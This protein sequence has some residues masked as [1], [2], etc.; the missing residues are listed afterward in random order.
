MGG[1]GSGGGGA[2][3]PQASAAKEV[4]ISVVKE[5]CEKR[6]WP[7]PVYTTA[8]P[9][10]AFVVICTLDREGLPPLSASSAIQGT[11]AKARREAAAKMAALLEAEEA[12]QGR[13]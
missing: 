9:P 6:K 12:G 5:L 10:S 4:A 1:G 11:K 13:A 8:G 2:P 7:Q 3:P